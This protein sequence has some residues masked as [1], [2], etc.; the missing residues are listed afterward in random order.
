M[1]HHLEVRGILLEGLC[2]QDRP[3]VVSPGQAVRPDQGGARAAPV[4]AGASAPRCRR[5]ECQELR[6]RQRTAKCG[7]LTEQGDRS[8]QQDDAGPAR[9]FAGADDRQAEA[10]HRGWRQQREVCRG[11]ALRLVLGTEIPAGQAGGAEERTSDRQVI[12]RGREGQPATDQVE[13]PAN[14]GR[15]SIERPG[16][17]L[18]GSDTRDDRQRDQPRRGKPGR[19]VRR[20]GADH[21]GYR[22]APGGQQGRVDDADNEAHARQDEQDTIARSRIQATSDDPGP[23][24]TAPAGRRMSLMLPER[25]MARNR[26]VMRARK[27]LATCELEM[28]MP[29]LLSFGTARPIAAEE[30]RAASAD[31]QFLT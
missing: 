14:A 27:S 17:K 31:S 30:I 23:P 28:I 10:D 11:Q 26:L 29:C 15:I 12:D 19:A 18:D 21:L 6:E 13:R 24:G 3:D 16:E 1:T 25:P 2:V 5:N 22:S 9:K 4:H 20:G 7:E 8:N